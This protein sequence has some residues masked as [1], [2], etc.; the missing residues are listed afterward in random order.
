MRDYR[1]LIEAVR[2][3]PIHLVIAAGS[4]WSSVKF[5]LGS[6]LTLPRNVEISSL[7][8]AEMRELYRSAKLVVIPI[9]PTLR[10]CGVSVLLEAW[11]M[12]RPVIVTRTTGLL[13]YVSDGENAVFVQPHDVAAMRATIVRLLEQPDEA[14]RLARNGR[15]AIEE[16][17]NLDRYVRAAC[18]IILSAVVAGAP[19]HA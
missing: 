15:K 4:A 8:H 3:I 16:C 5:D 2:G 6:E 17:F 12:Q 13:D 9:R 7:A 11:A 1:T 18:S 19:R 14:E 10:S